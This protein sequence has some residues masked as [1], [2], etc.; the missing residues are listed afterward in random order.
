M[1]LR[2][3]LEWTLEVHIVAA[4]RKLVYGFGINDVESSS[5]IKQ[6]DGTYRLCDIYCRWSNMIRR[7]YHTKSMEASYKD[8]QV[9]EEWS[10]LKAFSSWYNCF[11]EEG[12]VIDK[13]LLS[14]KIYSPDTCL[15]V[16]PNVNSFITTSG[17]Q[18]LLPSGVHFNKEKGKFCSRVYNPFSEKRG[19]YKHM[20]YVPTAEEATIRFMIL[21]SEYADILAST[22]ENTKSA[23]CL[24]QRYKEGHWFFKSEMEKAILFDKK[25]LERG[26]YD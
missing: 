22:L 6:E 12:M 11:H 13:D 5:R 23:D 16:P 17:S 2:I 26:C 10:S 20:G 4:H 24:R 7:C 21:K 25:L 1:L 9:A 14:G 15:F 18:Y 19:D 3:Y 8:C